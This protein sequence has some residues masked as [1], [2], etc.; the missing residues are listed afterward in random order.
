MNW[1]FEILKIKKTDDKTVEIV[2]RFTTGAKSFDR[3]FT[4]TKEYL[5]RDWLERQIKKEISIFENAKTFIQNIS[6]GSFKLTDNTPPPLPSSS[7]PT[8]EEISRNKF[9]TKLE[10]LKKKTRLVEL[11]VLQQS[12]LTALITEVQG[13]YDE[14][15]LEKIPVI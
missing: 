1:T 15:Y 5:S 12:D 10:L 6:I 2:V 14:V 11:G 7:P 4:A 13:L 8:Q 9:L 3:I